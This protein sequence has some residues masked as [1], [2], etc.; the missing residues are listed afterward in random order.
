MTK[1]FLQ[2]PI[3]ILPKDSPINGLISL[4]FILML[5]LN[6]MFGFRVACLESAFFSSYRIQKY[7]IE[8]EDLGDKVARLAHIKTI[9]PI[10]PQEYRL[11]AY[12]TPCIISFMINFIRLVSTGAKY[13]QYIKKYPQILIASCFTPFV[14]EGNKENHSIQIWKSGSVVNAIFIG[15]L[16]QIVLIVMDF[17]RGIINWDFIGPITL[18]PE[19]VY[20]N[21]DALF[22][23]NYGNSLFAIVSG[24]GFFLLIMFAFFTDTIFKSKGMYCK[25]CSILCLPC[26]QNCFILSNTLNPPIPLTSQADIVNESALRNVDSG[27]NLRETEDVMT[28]IYV[29][30]NG[31]TKWLSGK[32][33]SAETTQSKQV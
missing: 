24:V 25:C 6:C 14:F 10:I 29:Y 21:N 9:D 28:K 11:I 20:E 12:F 4:P 19:H 8:F 31:T 13:M 33:S 32:P 1:F 18:S 23:S 15:C 22:K 3:S 30:S 5:C 16:P 7:N 26:P 27:E 2:G 17:Y